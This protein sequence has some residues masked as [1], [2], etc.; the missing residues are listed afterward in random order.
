MSTRTVTEYCNCGARILCC[1]NVAGVPP[2]VR[3]RRSRHQGVGHKSCSKAHADRVLRRRERRESK[4]KA[5][6]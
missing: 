1:T 2:S 6:A 5:H 4:G 3:E